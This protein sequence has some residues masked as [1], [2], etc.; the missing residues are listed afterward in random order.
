MNTNSED[1][2]KKPKKQ[3]KA[4]QL[5]NM[6]FCFVFK[7][8]TRKKF[9]KRLLLRIKGPKVVT[10][11]GFYLKVKMKLFGSLEQKIRKQALL[12]WSFPHPNNF[13]K[14]GSYVMGMLNFEALW[15]AWRMHW[16]G[17]DTVLKILFFLILKISKVTILLQLV[18]IS[19]PLLTFPRFCRQ[20]PCRHFDISPIIN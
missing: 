15:K 18:T 8:V 12:A 13:S 11:L 10:T 3:R 19:I 14:P 20:S 2:N 16:N 7:S 1:K 4:K 6:V 17:I 9:H 5:S